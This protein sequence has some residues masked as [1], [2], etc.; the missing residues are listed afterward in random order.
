MVSANLAV[1]V[2]VADYLPANYHHGQNR[3]WSD[4]HVRRLW[5]DDIGHPRGVILEE[6]MLESHEV[7]LLVSL[8][9]FM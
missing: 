4:I 1:G 6:V 7:H 2:S 8:A 9:L 5:V 3:G